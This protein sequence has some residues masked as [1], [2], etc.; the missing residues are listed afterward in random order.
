MFRLK[1]RLGLRP[2]LKHMPTLK[3]LFKIGNKTECGLLGF[4]LDLNQ[5]FEEIRR[6][7]PEEVLV[8]VWPFHT[9]DIKHVQKMRSMENRQN[10]MIIYAYPTTLKDQSSR[11]KC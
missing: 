5:S 3:S 10:N 6:R 11:K 2:K 7:I 9:A 1:L 4:V 8:K